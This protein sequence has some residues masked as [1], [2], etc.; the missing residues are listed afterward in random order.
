MSFYVYCHIGSNLPSH[1]YDSIESVFLVEPEANI[2][3]ITD[4]NI[5]IDKVKILHTED[6]I[7]PETKEVMTMDLFRNEE[8]VLWRTSIFRIFLIRDALTHLQINSC[9]HF[10]NDVI[11]FQ[12]SSLF[13]YFIPSFKGIQI[14]SCNSDEMVFGFS[15]FEDIETV[16]QIC[17]ILYDIIFDSEKLKKYYTTMP[18]EMQ[19]LNGIFKERPDLIKEIPTVPNSNIQYI[20]DPS[21]YGQYF[22]GTDNGHLPEW[23]G[24]HHKIGQLISTKKIV[25]M[26]IEN[27]PYVLSNQCFYPIVNLHI[28][29]KNTKFF[30]N[31]NIEPDTINLCIEEEFPG[32]EM[33]PLERAKLYTWLSNVVKP[34]NDILEVGTGVGGSTYFIA[35]ALQKNKSNS[36]I[37]TCDPTRSPHEKL[38]REFQ[39]IKYYQTTSTYL[40]HF[41]K[42]KKTKL[43]FIFFDG[44]EDAML[45]L[46]D[47]KLLETYIEP[48]CFFSMH[49]WEIEQR[50]RDG[51]VSQKS[52][53][54]RQYIENSNSW[55]KI[56]ILDGLNYNN[57]VGLCLY[58]FKGLQ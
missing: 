27:K 4:Q 39:N 43:D 25:P 42:A 6:I 1:L 57:S 47:F 58:K 30:I 23:T 5:L 56:E 21:S 40:I 19:L 34:V 16:N 38:L 7:T 54:I 2:A 48:N 13:K 55:E 49:D 24:E 36:T 31:K 37:H 33:L 35:K 10:D 3:V 15:K 32:S 41:L 9:Y 22:S 17:K 11:L 51:V 12:P 29:S 53:H 46:N 20:F 44:P 14:T 8:N 26:F 50:K 18:N 28:H 52:L 45:A